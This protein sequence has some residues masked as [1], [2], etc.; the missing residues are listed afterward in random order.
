[1]RVHLPA[2]IL[3]T[4]TTITTCETACLLLRLSATAITAC[5]TACLL[6]PFP[7]ASHLPASMVTHP[8]ACSLLFMMSGGQDLRTISFVSALLA[9]PARSTLLP[10][11]FLSALTHYYSF[12]LHRHHA[13]EPIH[14]SPAPVHPIPT[15]LTL[16]CSRRVRSVSFPAPTYRFH[17]ISPVSLHPHGE[18][19]A[20]C[21]G[22][23][24]QDGSRDPQSTAAGCTAH[25]GT[26]GADPGI[27]VGSQLCCQGKTAAKPQL[28]PPDSVFCKGLS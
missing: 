20:C 21:T 28:A 5:E 27:N 9:L 19:N 26:R 10:L 17:V 14:P 3:H 6:L 11:P 2:I 23:I 12:L 22:I 24:S 7:H 1:M 16:A 25:K 13:N 8:C 4:T 18:L 15:K